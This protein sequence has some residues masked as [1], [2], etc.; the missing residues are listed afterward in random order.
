MGSTVS[1]ITTT[2][3]TTTAAATTMTATPAGTSVVRGAMGTPLSSS[4]FITATSRKSP[5]N[6]P[7]SLEQ[8]ISSSSLSD[9]SDN[10]VEVPH[11]LFYTDG[12]ATGNHHT[13]YM[14][15]IPLEF[16]NNVDVNQDYKSFI[17]VCLG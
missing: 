11:N 17:E 9:P 6:P 7:Y 5:S 8:S 16:E 2:T 1:A 4:P 13:G 10:S 3:T 12:R 15:I 14:R